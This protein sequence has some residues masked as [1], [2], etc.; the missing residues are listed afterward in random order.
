[1]GSIK[2]FLP[3]ETVQNRTRTGRLDTAGLYTIRY[4]RLSVKRTTV[5][6]SALL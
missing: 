3:C 4:I 1:V 6:T 2:D 5:G